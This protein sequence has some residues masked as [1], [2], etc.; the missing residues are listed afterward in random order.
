MQS[1]TGVIR[2]LTDGAEYCND[3]GHIERMK[4]GCLVKKIRFDVRGTGP[5][6]R[7]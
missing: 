2:E 6:G 5:R 3:L 1:R 7:P 4:K